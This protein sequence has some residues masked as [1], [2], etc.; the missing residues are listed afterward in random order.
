MKKEKNSKP[1]TRKVLFV[2]T[3]NIFRSFSAE[4]LLKQYLAKHKI[5][6]WEVASAGTLAE[7]QA[8]DKQ[9]LAELKAL[10][11]KDF[12]HKQQKLSMAMLKKYDLVIAMAEDHAAFIKKELG[13]AHS[14][15]FNELVRDEHSSIWDIEDE[16]KDYATNRRA[17]VE[18]VS[19]TIKYIH[20]SIP[21]LVKGIEERVYLF[22][23]FANGVNKRRHN[24]GFPVIKLYETPNTFAFMS[25]SIPSK[26]DGH[27]L[28][29]PKKRYVL[30]HE[31]PHKVLVELLLTIQKIG[32]VLER[33]H[34]GYNVLINN[35]RVADQYIFHAHFHLIPRDA[36]DQIHLNGWDNKEMTEE[37]FVDFNKKLKKIINSKVK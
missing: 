19:K 25:I 30:L 37:Q 15:L 23:D 28:V 36:S 26:E 6:G 27:I 32:E 33:N 31:I 13:Y 24:N 29:I 35:G 7:K 1:I 18:M 10:G 8:V 17:V 9:V 4:V 16:V 11:V 2:C 14:V 3:G 20:D 34:G 22:S 5:K 12:S 21:N